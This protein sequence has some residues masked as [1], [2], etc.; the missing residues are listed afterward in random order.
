VTFNRRAGFFD[1]NN[2][3]RSYVLGDE[4]A[5]LMASYPRGE[6]PKEPFSYF[7]EVMTGFEYTL[8][9]GLAYE[10]EIDEALRVVADIRERYDGR[11]RN[12]YDE[13]EC[14]HHYARAMASWGVLLALSGF[15]YD[16]VNKT[17]TIASGT[18]FFSTG[19][20]WGT[21]TTEARE[22]TVR[23]L[24][25]EFRLSALQISGVGSANL[26]SRVLT[27]GDELRLPLT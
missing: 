7:T 5:V 3:M 14:G 8:A 25:G 19:D 18:H 22:S 2:V 27:E 6:R 24:G 21:V 17:M 16:G 9:A 20:A 11:R 15:H 10:G 4:T 1:H 26:D 23:V 12:P 13:A